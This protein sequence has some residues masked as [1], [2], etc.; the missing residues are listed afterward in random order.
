M[1]QREITEKNRAW[2]SEEIKIWKG[3]GIISDVHAARIWDLYVN[4][5]ESAERRH[6]LAR[7]TLLC[8]ATLMMGLAVLLMIAYNWE[9]IGRPVKLAIIFG[10]VLGAYGAAFWLRYLRQARLISELFFFLGCLFYGAAIWLIAQI[11]NINSHYPDGVWYWALGVLPF[12]LCLD[13]LLFHCLYAGL[14]ATWVGC[15]TL[16]FSHLIDWMFS[17]WGMPLPVSYSL[18]LMVLPGIV[19]AYRKGSPLTLAIY[20]SVIAWWIVLYPLCW[21]LHIDPM[22]W[23]TVSGGIVLMIALIHGPNNNMAAPYYILG[24]GMV[25]AGLVPLSFA[26]YLCNYYRNVELVHYQIYTGIGFIVVGLVCALG[27][28]YWAQKKHSRQSGTPVSFGSQL[29]SM[30]IPLAIIGS[31][32]FLC[33]WHGMMYVHGMSYHHYYGDSPLRW[34]YP[35]L[36]PVIIVNILMVA[37]SIW[38]IRMGM[39]GDRAKIF[40]LGVAYFLLW[41]ILRYFDLFSGV[42]GMLGAAAL[43]LT[44]GVALYAVARLWQRRKEIS[45]V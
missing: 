43:F 30:S 29:V 33:I 37:F 25:L 35:I 28:A 24:V 27:S 32:G 9:A 14:L 8:L 26:D 41:A 11:F 4:V 7:F 6:S 34:T 39:K 40:A 21:Q 38:L 45:H 18:P 20:L 13:T 1:T 36:V 19:W 23:V 2:L 31:M 15:E 12:V 17:N 42:G 22:Y 16:G 44:C 3:N 5:Q 10:A